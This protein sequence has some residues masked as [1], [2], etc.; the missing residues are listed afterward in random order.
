[1]RGERELL[2][3]RAA[4][5]GGATAEGGGGATAEG[6]TGGGGG[7]G[8]ATAVTAFAAA[9]GCVWSFGRG[10]RLIFATTVAP[11]TSFFAC[12]NHNV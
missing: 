3:G 2:A 10:A 7:C 9:G 1:M 11:C 4:G 5:G 12:R 8:G 6:A